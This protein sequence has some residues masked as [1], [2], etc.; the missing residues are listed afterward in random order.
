M[1]G[2]SIS[3]EASDPSSRA[4]TQTLGCVSVAPRGV[5]DSAIFE[6]GTTNIKLFGISQLK[7]YHRICRL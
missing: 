2:F 5:S 4:Y 6:A 1:Y 7:I 3:E